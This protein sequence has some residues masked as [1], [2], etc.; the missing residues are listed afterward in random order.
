MKLLKLFST[1]A[2]LALMPVVAAP[3]MAAVSKAVGTALNQAAKS[4]GA[5]AINAINTAKAA[6]KTPEERTKVAQMAAYVYTKA[7]QYGKAADEL[8]A[9]GAATPKQLASLYYNAG[10]YTKAVTYAK[11]AGGDDMQVLMAQA[12]I[13][14]GHYAEAVTS[15]N[16]LIASNGPKPLYLENLAGAQYKSGDKKGYLATTEKL[17]R[18]DPS[19]ARWKTLL[20]EQQKNQMQPEAKLALFELMDATGNLTRPEDIQEYAKLAIVNNQ[21]G[22]AQAVLTKAGGTL[23][24]DPMTAKLAQAAAQRAQ[25]AGANAAKLAADPATANVAGG[26]YFG[27]GQY[28]AAAAAYA[29]SAAAG[30]PYVDRAKVFQGISQLKAGNAAAA[31]AT[32]ASVGEGGMKDIADLWK[33]YASTKG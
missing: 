21:P 22:V 18:S 13:K 32:F 28:P 25:A 11:Q 4:S 27:L 12:A 31:K 8:Q 1:V 16:K 33:L 15:Y 24:S 26:A 10:N 30:G 29:K 5:A 17:V 6:A 3:A 20:V 2:A 7:G 19:P 14:Q 9:G 23:G